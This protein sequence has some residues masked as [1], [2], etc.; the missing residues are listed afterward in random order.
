MAN[1]KDVYEFECKVFEPQTA[2]LPQKEIKAMLKQLYQYFPYIESEEGKKPY[3]SSS[4]Y[5]KKWFQSYSHLLML[6]DMK[7]QEAKHNIS[8][9]L[10]IIAIVVSVTGV[11]V[12]FST[13]S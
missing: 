11:L 4:E 3:D 2:D 8:M 6:L 10:S 13:I 1:F 5:S 9:W 7:R 12:R